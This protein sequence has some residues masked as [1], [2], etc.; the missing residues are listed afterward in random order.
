MSSMNGRIRFTAKI[1][2][3]ILSSK[4]FRSKPDLMVKYG[5]RSDR[6]AEHAL[7]MNGLASKFSLNSSLLEFLGVLRV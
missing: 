7:F 4:F 1:A 2:K 6:T 3:F 5:I